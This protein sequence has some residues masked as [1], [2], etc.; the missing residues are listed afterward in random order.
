VS[1]ASHLDQVAL[2]T[3]VAAAHMTHG[4]LARLVLLQVGEPQ[5][6]VIAFALKW[7]HHQSLWTRRFGV[8]NVLLM[9]HA[10]ATGAK[11]DAERTLVSLM[12]HSV[13]PLEADSTLDTLAFD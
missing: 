12:L 5:Q 4:A 3:S 1:I 13:A 2:G 8:N 6:L 11:H 7:T 9:C 10:L